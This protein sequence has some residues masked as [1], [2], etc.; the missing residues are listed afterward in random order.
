V[1]SSSDN[2]R[3]HLRVRGPFDGRRVGLLETPVRIYDLCE[4]G[5][6]VTTMYEGKPGEALTLS[7]QLPYEGWVKVEGETLYN[8]PGFGFAVRFTSL[9]DHARA[10]LDRVVQRLGKRV[11]QAV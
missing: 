6:F 10:A 3:K 9:T 5:C 8:K 1:A 11:L 2:S 4:G 7:I